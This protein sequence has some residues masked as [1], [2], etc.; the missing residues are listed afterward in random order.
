MQLSDFFFL[1]KKKSNQ[2]LHGVVKEV[3][4]VNRPSLCANFR[5]VFKGHTVKII[6]IYSDDKKVEDEGYEESDAAFNQEVLVGLRN[7][8][9]V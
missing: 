4:G 8:S 2:F 9:F 3:I 5:C 6:G 7:R 1:K